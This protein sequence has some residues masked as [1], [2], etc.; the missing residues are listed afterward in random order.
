MFPSNKYHCNL[1][2]SLKSFSAYTDYGSTTSTSI[3]YT[4]TVR[5]PTTSVPLNVPTGDPEEF[6]PRTNFI[7]SW[8]WDLLNT[9]VVVFIFAFLCCFQMFLRD[10]LMKS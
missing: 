3:F 2:M 5:P 6:K 1:F 8:I 9:L 7:E 4:S 10:Y